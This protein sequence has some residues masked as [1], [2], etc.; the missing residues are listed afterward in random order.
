M[1][2]SIPHILQYDVETVRDKVH[3]TVREGK[4]NLEN[5]RGLM[6]QIVDDGFEAVVS[7]I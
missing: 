2:L 1:Q 3:L 7:W 4:S 5:C 6:V